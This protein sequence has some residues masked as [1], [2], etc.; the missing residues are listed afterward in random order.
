LKNPIGTGIVYQNT[1][2]ASL[3]TSTQ[4]LNNSV[5]YTLSQFTLNGVVIPTGTRVDIEKQQNGNV[6]LYY[7]GTYLETISEQVSIAPV[8]ILQ[9]QPNVNNINMR[10]QPSTTKIPIYYDNSVVAVQGQ[11]QLET[12]VPM[13][14]ETNNY[15]V[16][17]I[18]IGDTANVTVEPNTK[19]YYTSEFNTFGQLTFSENSTLI[20]EADKQQ[21]EL[22]F[23]PYPNIVKPNTIARKIEQQQIL[24][25]AKSI[26]DI[27]VSINE[28]NSINTDKVDDNE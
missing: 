17:F 16:T 1:G 7:N 21:F 13:T 24:A 15:I 22:V 19:F 11:I 25:I 10:A 27:A 18:N 3:T 12:R 5:L 8:W 23:G 9:N 6:E 20:F 14:Y 4:V 2:R 28:G 26:D